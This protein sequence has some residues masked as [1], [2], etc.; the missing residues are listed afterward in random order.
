MQQSRHNVILVSLRSYKGHILVV[1]LCLNIPGTVHTK[2]HRKQ[3]VGGQMECLE[4]THHCPPFR[5]KCMCGHEFGPVGS[6]AVMV[7]VSCC[8]VIKLPFA[9]KTGS[10]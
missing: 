1:N 5:T 10:I 7:S 4:L 9:S 6:E 2:I 8:R 3:I